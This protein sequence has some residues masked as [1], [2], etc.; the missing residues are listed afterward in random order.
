MALAPNFLLVGLEKSGTHWISGLLNAHPEV[1]CIPFAALFGWQEKY[2]KEFFGE[3][4][5]F[6]TLASL[7]PGNENKFSRPLENF[8]T[9]NNGFFAD[10]VSKKDLTSKDELYKMFIERYNELCEMHRQGKKIIGESSPAYIFYLDFIDSFYPDIKKICIIRD[11]K[12]RVVSWNFNQIRKGRKEEIEITDDFA[13]D[14]CQSRILK[15]YE[16]I[17]AYSGVIH[18]LTYEDLSNNTAKTTQ[19]ILEYLGVNTDESIIDHMIEEAAFE[20]VS[21]QD[22]NLGGRKKGEELIASHYRKGIVGDWKNYLT[23]SQGA[24]IDELTQDLQ[25]KVFKKYNVK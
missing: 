7:E 5:L 9:R 10:L 6:N 24:L 13:I 21:T 3:V 4:H 2:K 22:N 19:G 18:C 1:A 14:Y 23:A 25:N 16:S 17:L 20:K 11:P 15:E 8:L 12:D